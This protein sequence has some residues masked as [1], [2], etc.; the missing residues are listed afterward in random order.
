MAKASFEVFVRRREVVAGD[1]IGAEPRRP[2]PYGQKDA[3]VAAHC[4]REQGG[5]VAALVALRLSLRPT[6]RDADV[7]GSPTAWNGLPIS[8]RI[9]YDA[10]VDV[11]LRVVFRDEARHP[12]HAG[13]PRGSAGGSIVNLSS[14]GGPTCAPVP[15]LL[16]GKGRRPCGDPVAAID[17]ADGYPP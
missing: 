5:A 6:R 12:R 2:S 16:G 7:A 3:V 1:I 11:D 8:P 13:H 10:I 14:V 9:C 17:A 15:P 4:E